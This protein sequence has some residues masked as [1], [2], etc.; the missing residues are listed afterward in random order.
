MKPYP[1]YLDK[2]NQKDF[3]SEARERLGTT[4]YEEILKRNKKNPREEAIKAILTKKEAPR[5]TNRQKKD[6]QV[7][8]LAAAGID[9]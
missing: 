1:V 5:S 7:G 9:N 8:R 6:K 3:D 4:F 2:L